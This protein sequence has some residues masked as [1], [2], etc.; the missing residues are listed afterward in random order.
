MTLFIENENELIYS[1]VDT[2]PGSNFEVLDYMYEFFNKKDYSQVLYLATRN[3]L[4]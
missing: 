4:E 2:E 3:E 1:D